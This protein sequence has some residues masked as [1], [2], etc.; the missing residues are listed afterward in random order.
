MWDDAIFGKSV[1]L[2]DCISKLS[3]ICQQLDGYSYG[4]SDVDGDQQ[5]EKG[6]PA[7]FRAKISWS[8]YLK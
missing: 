8:V 6:P 2:G 5:V 4:S 3:S 7:D 1:M